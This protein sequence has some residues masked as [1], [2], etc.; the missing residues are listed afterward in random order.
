MRKSIKASAPNSNTAGE[1][2]TRKNLTH[3][4]FCL[5]T[6]RVLKLIRPRKISSIAIDEHTRT[7]DPTSVPSLNSPPFDIVR[8]FARQAIFVIPA[9]IR[10]PW[11]IWFFFSIMRFSRV[12]R[13][14]RTELGAA[15][16]P[17][18]SDII[19]RLNTARH[20]VSLQPVR[21]LWLFFTWQL[22]NESPGYWY[23]PTALVSL[24]QL[25]PFWSMTVDMLLDALS[26]VR[27]G[28]QT[29]SKSLLCYSISVHLNHL[30]V[31][32][33]TFA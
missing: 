1:F 20:I 3:G 13:A 29:K 8:A 6:G 5:L 32:N 10:V 23:L 9:S 17:P 21:S 18:H 27:W 28:W 14:E 26:H 22:P 16:R 12:L 33:R 25:P 15:F 31:Y 7:T 19:I 11:K 2:R 30:W 24:D 4:F